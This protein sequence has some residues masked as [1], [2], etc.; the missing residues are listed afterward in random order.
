MK[1]APEGKQVESAQG[2]GQELNRSESEKLGI[3]QGS[4]GTQSKAFKYQSNRFDGLGK[5]NS[6][7]TM[8]VNEVFQLGTSH[9]DAPIAQT[10]VAKSEAKTGS[11]MR[12]R[13]RLDEKKR[14]SSASA[15]GLQSSTSARPHVE[16][17]KQRVADPQDEP[18]KDE[19]D[20][21]LRNYVFEDDNGNQ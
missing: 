20:K 14:M 12:F 17:S 7:S 5:R 9:T 10:P 4:G 6:Q 2:G 13:Q 21:S 15:L 19:E 1:Q 3:A 16:E 18:E 11:L 8:P